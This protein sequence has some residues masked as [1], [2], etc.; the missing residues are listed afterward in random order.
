MG[1]EL[2]LRVSM[3]RSCV[4]RKTKR[5]GDGTGNFEDWVY[6]ELLRELALN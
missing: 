3:D 2:M 4:W 5:P 1:T 6:K